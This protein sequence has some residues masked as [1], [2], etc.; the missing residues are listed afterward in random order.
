MTQLI[1]LSGAG[2]TGKTSVVEELH[3][4]MPDKSIIHRSIVREF[5]AQ[6]G[7]ANETEFLGL[8]AGQ[9]HEFQ[10]ALFNH[11]LMRIE[12]EARMCT[13]DV[14]LCERSVFDHFAYT[15][16]GTR[17]LLTAD[18][19]QTLWHGVRRFM[20]LKPRTF[21][22][23][24]PTPWDKDGADGFRAREVAKDTLV[25]A[26]IAKLLSQSRAAWA[27]T[28]PF[29]PVYDRAMFIVREVWNAGS[30][31]NGGTP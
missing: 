8:P 13:R 4:L 11:Y 6:E 16:Y 19:L 10:L 20:A 17:E 21:Y 25:D 7:V 27:G 26:M 14:M 23:P 2:A 3:R 18:D 22:L 5:Y 29:L 24:Y 15:L 31:G 9:R 30:P 28:V 12:E 1:T